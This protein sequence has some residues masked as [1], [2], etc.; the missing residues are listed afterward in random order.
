MTAEV[1]KKT[2]K[3]KFGGSSKGKTTRRLSL[4]DEEVQESIKRKMLERKS[5]IVSEMNKVDRIT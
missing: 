1:A 4:F 3:K 2:A 5:G